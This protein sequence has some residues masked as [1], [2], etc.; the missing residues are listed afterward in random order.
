MCF[1][2]ND[3]ANRAA[4]VADFKAMLMAVRAGYDRE[5]S[6]LHLGERLAADCQRESV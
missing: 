6:G 3:A 2:F 1:S 5:F 4:F